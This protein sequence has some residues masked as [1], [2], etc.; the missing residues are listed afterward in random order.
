MRTV[1]CQMAEAKKLSLSVRIEGKSGS[2]SVLF[3]ANGSRI[4]F[5]GF[6]RAYVEG[7]DDPDAELSER[8][9]DR[10]SCPARERR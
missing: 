8:L 10:A 1:S 7:S 5:P 6:L 2:D 3:G 4:I 9:H